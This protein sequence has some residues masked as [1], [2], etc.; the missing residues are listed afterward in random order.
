M[1]DGAKRSEDWPSSSSYNLESCQIGDEALKLCLQPRDLKSGF[2]GGM[3]LA[4]FVNHCAR[5][6]SSLQ[7]DAMN[8]QSSWT[9]LPAQTTS[10][11]GKAGES[12]LHPSDKPHSR[13][14]VESVI[15]VACSADYARSSRGTCANFSTS[16]SR[17]SNT[18]CLWLCHVS[19]L[20]SSVPS[21]PEIAP[22]PIINSFLS[23]RWS[24]AFGRIYTPGFTTTSAALPL[25]SW[26][27]CYATRLESPRRSLQTLQLLRC[28]VQDTP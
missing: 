25:L 22:A 17:S 9:T 10:W 4:R 24:P 21:F 26:L 7:G 28:S 1:M 23:P 5:F 15:S 14:T 6:G 19:H 3:N 18:A 12:Q 27:W 8:H 20:E 2:L 11:N 13:H 16:S